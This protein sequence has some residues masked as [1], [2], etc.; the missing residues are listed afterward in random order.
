M[1]FTS[2]CGVGTAP[3]AL[4]PFLF[5]PTQETPSLPITAGTIYRTYPNSASSTRIVAADV[6][7]A[8]TVLRPTPSA[9]PVA[10]NPS[11]Q[12]ISAVT[13]PKT[14]DLVK[15]NTTSEVRKKRWTDSKNSAG[16]NSNLSIVSITA[17]TIATTLENTASIGIIVTA[18]T[19]RGILRYRFRSIAIISSASNCS[20][21]AIVPSCAAMAPPTRPAITSAVNT[22]VNSVKTTVAMELPKYG[23]AS[24][25]RLNLS[26]RFVA[27][28]A[29]IAP[30][31]L[32]ISK[33]SGSESTPNT[34]IW[35]RT[36]RQSFG[37]R[38]RYTTTL[39]RRSRTRPRPVMKRT[40]Q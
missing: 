18:A 38:G 2:A 9:P 8:R 16:G 30:V 25:S 28:N 20:E 11:T 24:D 6:V 4:S 19:T 36:S 26:K 21:T 17:P 15:P 10:A 31:K 37:T 23:R 32:P 27:C 12:P 1:E 29:A 7:N 22:G 40:I 3:K 13:P 35:R 33:T 34:A 39:P 5:A 14:A